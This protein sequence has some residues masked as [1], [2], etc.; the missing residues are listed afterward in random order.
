[1]ELNMVIGE[2]V[3]DIRNNILNYNLYLQPSHINLNFFH[4][5]FLLFQVLL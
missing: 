4:I 5:L 1:M 2:K 3:S